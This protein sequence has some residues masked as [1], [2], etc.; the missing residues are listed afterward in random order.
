RGAVCREPRAP[1][2]RAGPPGGDEGSPRGGHNPDRQ[3]MAL[4]Q[5][6]TRRRTER[7]QR[8]LSRRVCDA[9]S[10]RNRDDEAAPQEAKP[11]RVEQDGCGEPDAESSP[12]TAREREVQR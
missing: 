5:R 2:K 12:A 8:V 7:R 4:P 11:P 3:S 10:R 9:E 6:L 1:G